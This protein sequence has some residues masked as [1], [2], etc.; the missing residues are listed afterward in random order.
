MPLISP[1]TM[2]QIMRRWI[3]GVAIITSSDGTTRHG[4]TINS[5]ASMSLDPA[6]VMVSLA[7]GVRTQQLVE[8]TGIFGLSFLGEDQA[9]I[10][11]RFA[12]KIPEGNDRFSGLEWYTISSTAPLLKNGLA[13]LDCRVVHIYESKN[14]ILYVGEVIAEQMGQPGTPL[15]YHNREYHRI[16]K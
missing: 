13:S 2:R 7:C 11:D 16:E 14:S 8:K 3:T 6:L 4:M 5:L 10:S 15:V 9:E 1:D 12:G